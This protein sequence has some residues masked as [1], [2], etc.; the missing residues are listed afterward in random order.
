[1]EGRVAKAQIGPFDPRTE[2]GSLEPVLVL[3]LPLGCEK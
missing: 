1:V 2:G 3:K